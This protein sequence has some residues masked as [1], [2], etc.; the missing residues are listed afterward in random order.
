M[1]KVAMYLAIVGG[2]F[3]IISGAVGGL[4]FLQNVLEFASG[5]SEAAKTVLIALMFIA[6]LGGVA[7]IIGGIFIGKGLK[8]LGKLFIM[9]GAGIGLIGLLIGLGLTLAGGGNISSFFMSFG[10]LNLVG[11]VLSIAARMLA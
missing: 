1:S 3:L 7:V 6:S 4:G 10:T 9:L 8:R 5:Y 2:L 11:V